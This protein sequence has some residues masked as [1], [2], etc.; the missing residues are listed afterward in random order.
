LIDW[1]TL[2]FYFFG[3]VFFI[4]AV[5]HFA[6]GLMGR[7]FQS[8]FARPPGQGYSSSTVNVLWGALNFVVAYWLICRVGMFDLRNGP[9]V[10]AF[11]VG[12]LLSG[13]FLA[14]HFG[15]FNGGNNPTKSEKLP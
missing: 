1:P 14:H 5:P 2:L 11:G 15:R 3:G 10:A 4:N 6:A 13:L 12:G 9:D 7:P 8:P